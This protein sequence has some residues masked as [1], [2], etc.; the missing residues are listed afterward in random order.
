MTT[1][2][3]ACADQFDPIMPDLNRYANYLCD[4]PDQAPE[5]VQEAIKCFLARQ[6]TEGEIAHPKKY[7][8]SILYNL[9]CNLLRLQ[10]RAKSEIDVEDAVII[11]TKPS[12]EQRLTCLE[13]VEK[14]EELPPP[15][16]EIL[17]CVIEQDLTYAEMSHALNIPRGTVMS[18]L[19][20]ARQALRTAMDMETDETVAELLEDHA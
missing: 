6:Q 2:T 5:L 14:I 16:R 10:Q 19:S 8:F 18:R 20:R 12:Q 9:H 1:D 13:V 17:Q 15:Q 11:D 4:S 3:D 7:L